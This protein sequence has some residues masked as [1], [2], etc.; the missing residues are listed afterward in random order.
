MRSNLE[1]KCRTVQG[2]VVLVVVQ[3]D[4]PGVTDPLLR[5]CSAELLR[6]EGGQHT[7]QTDNGR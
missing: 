1:R 4:Y 3:A 7:G 6:R 5:L 2:V